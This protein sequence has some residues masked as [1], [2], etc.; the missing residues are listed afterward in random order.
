MIIKEAA[1]NHN[2]VQYVCLC[3]NLIHKCPCPTDTGQEVIR[4][5]ICSCRA[6]ARKLTSKEKKVNDAR[7]R[8]ELKAGRDAEK[9]FKEAGLTLGR[10][11]DE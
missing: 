1:V 9:K 6:P 5:D 10:V 2:H 3:G 7:H 4:F 11:Y 8:A